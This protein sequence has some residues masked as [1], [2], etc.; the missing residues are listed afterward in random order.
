LRLWYEIHIIVQFTSL[1][2]QF[3]IKIWFIW[4]SGKTQESRRIGWFIL[5]IWLVE[6]SFGLI[7]TD[8]WGGR[9]DLH[10]KGVFIS[11]FLSFDW[12]IWKNCGVV[13]LICNLREFYAVVRLICTLREFLSVHFFHFDWSIWNYWQFLLVHFFGLIRTYSRL[14]ISVLEN[15]EIHAK[16]SFVFPYMKV[17]HNCRG[18]LFYDVE[19]LYVHG[20]FYTRRFNGL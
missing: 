2:V 19:Y 20:R 3:W 11:P 12:S 4:S 9:T 17:F 10:L 1:Q 16:Q 18:E 13:G 7:W 14:G 6:R 5:L 8:L 15:C